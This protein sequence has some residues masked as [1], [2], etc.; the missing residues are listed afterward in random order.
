MEGDLTT[1]TELSRAGVIQ[2]SDGYR[3]KRQELGQPGFPILRVAQIGGNRN[4]TVDATDWVRGEFV[5][6]IGDKVSKK[7]DVVLTTKGTFGR[8]AVIDDSTSGWVYS[9]QVC[10]LRVLDTSRLDGDFLYYWLA[11]A[12]FRHQANARVAQTDMADYL[13][14]RDLGSIEVCLP[15]I[16][17]QRAIGHVLGTLDDKIE[18]NRRMNETLEAMARALF[19]SWF[20]DFEPVRT[21]G[22]GRELSI[23]EHLA[24]LFPGAF[25]E[26]AQGQI[27]SGWVL[28]TLGVHSVNLDAKRVPLSGTER[29]KRS[30][31]F[32]YHG[33]AGVLDHIDEYLFEGVHL[34]VGEDGSVL[35]SGGHAVTQYAWGQFWVNNHAHVLRGAG[36]VSTEQLYLYFQFESVAPYV[37]GAVQA[38]LSQG[39]M[40]A[41]PFVFPGE[42]LCRA[43]EHAVSPFFA[44]LRLNSDESRNLAALRD[45]LLPK[46]ISGELRVPDAERLVSEVV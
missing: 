4:V 21:K 33:A 7:G 17:H 37:T 8:R 18:Q 11:S 32:P 19:K 1:I 27:P 23:S 34:L 3:T 12:S 28:S 44:R 5:G 29:S 45:T 6:R 41:M 9:P 26:T 25:V 24:G 13:S 14:L 43:F 39:R 46:L 40:N 30:G 10:Y 2:F 16:R 31:P 15:P 38:K 35:T 22:E 36:P 42:A 20:V